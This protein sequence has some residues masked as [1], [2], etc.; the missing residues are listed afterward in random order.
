M[1]ILFLLVG[2]GIDP[3]II[4]DNR[5]EYF[6][7][8]TQR[9]SFD[10]KSKKYSPKD[11]QQ[12]GNDSTWI[13][14]DGLGTN[15]LR[16]GVVLNLDYWRDKSCWH[17]ADNVNNA[18]SRGL[19]V[20]SFTNSDS[21]ISAKEYIDQISSIT[22][23]FRPFSL[24]IGDSDGVYFLSSQNPTPVTLCVGK[25][26]GVSNGPLEEWEKVDK[27]KELINEIL[28]STPI[29]NDS[30]TIL[31]LG[32]TLLHEVLLYDLPLKDPSYLS[33]S[34]AACQI[35]SIFVTPTVISREFSD[36]D[37][38]LMDDPHAE[39]LKTFS[40]YNN[41]TIADNT[42]SNFIVDLFG[43]RTNTALVNVPD[44]NGSKFLILERD[45][46]TTTYEWSISQH[47]NI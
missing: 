46:N 7:R 3:T 10:T 45:L 20:S 6:N 44:A 32:N 21:L 14:F 19:L 1:C 31:E 35:S 4:L 42:K 23:E 38:L 24:I 17:L 37:I 22:H 5:D 13:A 43:T 28:S 40:I 18:K 33:T 11:L 47:S 36:E 9:G 29:S 2:S 8:P 41:D 25:L 26:Y 34:L 15:K 27:G 39:M 30:D 16:F 12:S